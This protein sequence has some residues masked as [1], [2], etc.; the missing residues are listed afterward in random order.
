MNTNIKTILP[1]G[2]EP[3]KLAPYFNPISDGADGK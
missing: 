3:V 2:K 1:L